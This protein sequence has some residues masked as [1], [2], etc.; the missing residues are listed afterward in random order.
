MGLKEASRREVCVVGAGMRGQGTS[1]SSSETEGPGDG[2][3]RLS[4]QPHTKGSE[5]EKCQ[6]LM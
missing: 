1:V 5:A 4:V 3:Q 2:L 6:I